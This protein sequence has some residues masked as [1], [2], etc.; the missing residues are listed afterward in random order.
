ME[1]DPAASFD[2]NLARFKAECERLDPECAKILFGNLETLMREG[3]TR[4]AVQEFNQ[5][6]L[7]ALMDLP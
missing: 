5:A 7:S 2:D 6:V 1:F 3:D 4:Q